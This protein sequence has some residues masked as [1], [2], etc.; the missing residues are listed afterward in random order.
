MVN[1]ETN[2]NPAKGIFLVIVAFLGFSIMSAFIKV[3]SVAGLKTQ[4]IMFFQNLIALIVILP[5]IF[6]DKKNS[7]KPKNTV[8]VYGRAIV[9][10]LSMYFYF[11]AVKLIPLVNATLLQSTT[12]IF[13]PILAFFI[14][15]KKITL[16]ILLVMITGFIGVA[17]VLHPGKGSL[18]PGDFIA[19]FS[20]LL[21]A[22]STVIIKILD[23][24]NEPVKVVMFYYLAI[25]TV[26]M[27]IWAIPTWS[28]PHGML[29]LYLVLSGVFY[30]L[31]Q[32]LLILS[33]KYASTTTISPFIY[34]AVVFSGVIDWIVWKE[35]PQVI[36][37][38][39]AL[40]VIASA[41]IS[42][43]HHTKHKIPMHHR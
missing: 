1:T 18:N 17:M 31:F 8:L 29:W 10:L 13:I 39:G 34:L 25:T 33:V 5:W 11:F 41:I 19:L 7:L 12:P 14:F 15:R 23:D 32:L 9:G 36:T 4:E 43:I 20:G 27:G 35:I 38:L 24:K 21:S 2:L 26:I 37:V 16:K 30:A 6:H 42:T 3:C 28:A 22:L 40:V